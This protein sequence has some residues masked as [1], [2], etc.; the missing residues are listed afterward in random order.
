MSA[1]D[2]L[3]NG[4]YLEAVSGFSQEISTSPSP[5]AFNNRGMAYLHLEDYDAALADFRSADAL[6][7]AALHTV[8]NGD[9]CGVALWMAGR[10]QEAVATWLA[11]VEASL[12]G[13]S[14]LRSMRRAFGRHDNR[15]TFSSLRSG[16][17]D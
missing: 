5:P 3:K 17:C 13:T 11:G 6:S 2:Q 8:C 14:R 9:L 16:R 1:W 15:S 12:A 10:Q 7:S 4:E